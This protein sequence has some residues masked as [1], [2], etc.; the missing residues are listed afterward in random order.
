MPQLGN[1]AHQPDCTYFKREKEDRRFA[2]RVKG[3]GEEKGSQKKK[4]R[5]IE[6]NEDAAED[7]AE[8]VTLAQKAKR[9]SAKKVVAS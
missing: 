6:T 1:N 9:S 7:A 5:E 4:G 2:R 8:D 3:P